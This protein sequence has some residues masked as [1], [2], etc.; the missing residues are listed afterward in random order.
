MRRIFVAVDISD[1]ARKKAGEYIVALRGDLPKFAASWVRPEKLHLT[2]RFI[3]DCGEAELKKVTEV[4]DS[5]SARMHS[6]RLNIT[7]TG[8]FPNE[9]RARVLWL[10]V[11]GETDLMVRAKDM[12]ENEYHSI[13]LL[14]KREAL[15]P[16]LTIARIK[17]I[18][19]CREVVVA[20]L[21]SHFEPIEFEVS[22]IVVYESELHPKGSSYSAVARYILG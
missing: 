2:L 4:V 16:H 14:G 15:T 18:G 7:G 9:K 5:V 6:F 11:G 1:E 3:G 20:H 12:F 19:W 10:G 21:N 8:V 17:N 22:E 13:G